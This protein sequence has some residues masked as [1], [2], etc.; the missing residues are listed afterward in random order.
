MMQQSGLSR[1]LS[2]GLLVGR[3]VA[4]ALQCS[5]STAFHCSVIFLGLVAFYVTNAVRSS[6]F[7]R[8]CVA[9]IIQPPFLA[10][11]F[12]CHGL[13]PFTMCPPPPCLLRTG[14][15]S[16]RFANHFPGKVPSA[17]IASLAPPRPAPVGPSCGPTCPAVRRSQASWPLRTRLPACGPNWPLFAV[18]PRPLCRR[19]VPETPIRDG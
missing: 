4:A 11:T 17:A 18:P 3:P 5:P 8:P 9:L 13:L 10:A 12:P 2:S 7:E 6:A 14:H 15:R 1:L 19:P 16:R